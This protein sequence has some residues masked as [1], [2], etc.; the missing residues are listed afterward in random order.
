MRTQRPDA[1]QFRMTS[2]VVGQKSIPHTF[3]TLRAKLSYIRPNSLGDNLCHSHLR[4]GRLT[5]LCHRL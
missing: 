5:G 4:D 1:Q 3:V 2:G